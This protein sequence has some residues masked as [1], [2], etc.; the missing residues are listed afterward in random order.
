MLLAALMLIGCSASPPTP[1]GVLL[2]QPTPAAAASTAVPASATPASSPE[3]LLA[4]IDRGAGVRPNDPVVADFG[5]ALDR[6][7]AKCPNDPRPRLADFAAGLQKAMADKGVAEGLPS[8]LQNVTDAIPG[9][10]S[11]RPCAEIFTLYGQI[12]TAKP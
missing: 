11:P 9:S 10:V 3:Y 5:R 8:I 12:R 1:A 4:I 2:G 6:L 7:A